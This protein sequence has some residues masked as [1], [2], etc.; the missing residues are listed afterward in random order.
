MVRTVSDAG[1]KQE[2]V[3]AVEKAVSCGA[4]SG[5]DALTG[6]LFSMEGRL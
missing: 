1:G 4:T 2:I 6:F 5:T 3:D